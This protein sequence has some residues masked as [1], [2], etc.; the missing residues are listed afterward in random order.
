MD[1]GTKQV[2]MGRVKQS[3]IISKHFHR[4]F[5]CEIIVFLILLKSIGLRYGKSL[6]TLVR[7]EKCATAGLG[8]GTIT[9]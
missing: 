8:I 7:P 5:S 3:A 6:F 9:V 4:R 2:G 1:V